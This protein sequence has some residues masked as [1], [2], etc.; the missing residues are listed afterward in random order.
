M[1]R[2]F[3]YLILVLVLAS[4]AGSKKVVETNN[5]KIDVMVFDLDRQSNMTLNVNKTVS[6]SKILEQVVALT[7]IEMLL[8]LLGLS[9]DEIEISLSNITKY[10]KIKKI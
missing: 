5:D 1:T 10:T 9:E 7:A 2:V 6:E 4:C 3:T 8:K